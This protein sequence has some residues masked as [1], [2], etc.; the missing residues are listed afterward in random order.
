MENKRYK[1]QCP[2]CKRIVEGTPICNAFCEC[3]AK[4]YYESDIW[5]DRKTGK[6][7]F[8]NIWNVNR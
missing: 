2:F 4:Y 7:V 1:R 3:G 5:K 6:E 8:G